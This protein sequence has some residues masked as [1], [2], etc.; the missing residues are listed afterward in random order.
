MFRSSFKLLYTFLILR[1]LCNHFKVFVN[2]FKLVEFLVENELIQTNFLMGK[3]FLFPKTFETG[4]KIRSFQT[5]LK[6]F[7]NRTTIFVNLLQFKRLQITL[8]SIA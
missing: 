4:L 6:C 7:L 8:T 5:F 2:F 1:H 3:G